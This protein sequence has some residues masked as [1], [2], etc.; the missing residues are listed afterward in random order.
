MLKQTK[1]LGTAIVLALLSGGL[2]PSLLRAED[3]IEKAGMVV[4]VT[5]GNQIFL[6]IKITSVSM[7]LLSGA[8]SLLLTGNV[9]LTK[10]IWD[11][12]LQGPYLITPEV[13]KKA[14]GER[15]ELSATK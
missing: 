2:A 14:V 11:D 8:L 10:Q 6:P 7:G 13:A 12:T 5:A 3:A 1:T 15:P 4:G 9:D